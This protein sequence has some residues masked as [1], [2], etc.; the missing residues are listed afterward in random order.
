MGVFLWFTS[1]FPTILNVCECVARIPNFET[2]AEVILNETPLSLERQVTSL[3]LFLPLIR[4]QG[5]ASL[6]ETEALS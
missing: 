6:R 4:R 5:L 2:K 3:V 1:Y